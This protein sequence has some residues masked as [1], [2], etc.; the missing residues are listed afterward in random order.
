MEAERKKEV[1]GKTHD[2][3]GENR[4]NNRKAEVV[5]WKSRLVDNGNPARTDK[6]PEVSGTVSGIAHDAATTAVSPA[7][8]SETAPE[9]KCSL[10]STLI[11]DFTAFYSPG[12]RNGLPIGFA[13]KPD[14][15]MPVSRE[16]LL[17]CRVGTNMIYCQ[18][19][20]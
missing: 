7:P 10:S 11:G 16:K 15:P 6:R 20:I 12:N 3:A 9:T 4:R 17:V 1:M 8:S 14:E 5:G 18:Q 2:S 19:S 13:Q